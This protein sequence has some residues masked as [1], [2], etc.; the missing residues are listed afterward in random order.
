M[1]ELIIDRYNFE[2]NFPNEIWIISRNKGDEFIITLKKDSD[3][4]IEFSWDY[5]YGGRG[6][7]HLYIPFKQ[8]RDLINELYDGEN[9]TI[10]DEQLNRLLDKSRKE[11]VEMLHVKL[12][13]KEKLQIQ[14]DL[15]NEIA[16]NNSDNYIVNKS[17]ELKLELNNL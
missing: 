1:S 14:I 4:E 17:R 16:T 5:G 2:P 13:Q 8:L 9:C 7:S 11:F 15:L 6:S 10:S 3:I 12:T